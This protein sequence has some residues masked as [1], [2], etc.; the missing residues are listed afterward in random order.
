MIMI[1]NGIPRA[2]G[3]V[4]ELYAGSVDILHAKVVYASH[5]KRRCINMHILFQTITLTVTVFPLRMQM[6]TIAQTPV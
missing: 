5:R 1:L 6:Y 2:Q 3:I 4:I